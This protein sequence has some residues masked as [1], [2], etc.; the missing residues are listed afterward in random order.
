MTRLLLFHPPQPPADSPTL[1]PPNPAPTQ[2]EGE[3]GG[4][5]F[6]ATVARLSALLEQREPLYRGADI[7][8]SLEGSGPDADIGAPAMEVCLRVL[9]AI[10]QRIKDD[11]GA[12]LGG[13]VCCGVAGGAGPLQA[14]E[15]GRG[16][17]AVWLPGALRLGLLSCACLPAPW[18][19]TPRRG[20]QAAHGL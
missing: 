2:K 17:A 3:A 1:P 12:P 11:A 7:T 4:D 20:A 19:H 13:H 18:N 15:G 6:D 5:A 10:N 14:Q 8:V 9:S 16:L